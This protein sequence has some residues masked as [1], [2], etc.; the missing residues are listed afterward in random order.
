[1]IDFRVEKQE[2]CLVFFKQLLSMK[3]ICTVLFI[4]FTSQAFAQQRSFDKP[5][6][7]DEAAIKKLFEE[8][9]SDFQ[10]VNYKSYLTHW[11]KVPYASFLYREGLFV[12]EALWK[13][14]DDFWKNRKASNVNRTRTNWNLRINGNAA[15]VTY[16]QHQ[17]NTD[18]K[19][20]GDTYEERYLEK[21]NGTWKVVNM[22]VWNVAEK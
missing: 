10:T 16:S 17:E 20:E 5:T 3:K 21:I 4:L 1:M 7:A 11:A 19:Q 2:F 12:G 18:T 8:E 22:T 6:N 14:M 13:K 9:A 15:F